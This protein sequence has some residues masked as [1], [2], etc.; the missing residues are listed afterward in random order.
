MTILSRVQNWVRSPLAHKWNT[1]AHSLTTLFHRIV[2][3][4]CRGRGR[5][6]I[7][8]PSNSIV[9]ST[10]SATAL[11]RTAPTYQDRFEDPRFELEFTAKR[12]IEFTTDTLRINAFRT[13]LNIGEIWPNS[14]GS[15]QLFWSAFHKSRIFCDRATFAILHELVSSEESELTACPHSENLMFF[16]ERRLGFKLLGIDDFLRA[17]LSALQFEAFVDLFLLL[18]PEQRQ[19]FYDGLPVS[20]QK[21]FQEKVASLPN[22]N[23]K[24]EMA[25][26]N[27]P[28]IT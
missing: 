11:V 20:S 3:C 28:K 17:E 10:V 22:G 8:S 13:L 24:F 2:G 25:T 26:L 18:Q 19:S 21:G 9:R 6:L 4:C 14:E 7:S 27:M 12:R 23:R 1:I 16:L 15:S 5:R